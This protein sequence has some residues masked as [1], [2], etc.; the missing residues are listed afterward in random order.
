MVQF[1]CSIVTMCH[2]KT[3]TQKLATPSFAPAMLA[4]VIAPLFNNPR[5][6]KKQKAI[7]YHDYC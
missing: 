3:K 2:D 4:I 6:I 1:L 7:T 5:I